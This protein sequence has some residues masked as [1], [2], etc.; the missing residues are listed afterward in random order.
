[1]LILPG[2]QLGQE[3]HRSSNSIIYRGQRE[4]DQAPVILKVLN[5]SYPT[6]LERAR[7]E[8][9]H[10]LL[11][12]VTGPRIIE[13]FTLLSHQHSLVLV[14]EDF[15]AISLKRWM[16][17][18]PL[19]LV[20]RVEVT[21]RVAAALASV[22]EQ[23]VIHKD[24]NPTNIVLNPTTGQVKLIDFGLATTLA[25]EEATLQRVE[26]M[27]GT[28]PYLA[29]EQT[30]RMN[31]VVDY[32]SDFYSLGVT[33]YEL[34]TGQLPFQSA[35]PL[36]LVHAH[37]ARDPVPPHQLS[38]DIPPV[39]SEIVLKLMA[40]SARAR[41]QSTHGLQTDLAEVLRQLQATGTV[42]SFPLGRQDLSPR[43]RLSQTLYG[44]AVELDA[45]L[46]AFERV[47]AGAT[48]LLLVTGYA[49]VGKTAL[50]NELHKPLLG[51]RGYFV[52]GKFDQ[53]PRNIPYSALLQTFRALVRQIL[54]ESDAQ[55]ARWRERLL[56]A[57]GPNGQLILDVIPEME[58]LIGPQPPAP[59]VGPTESQH[60]FQRVTQTLVAAFAAPEHP[61]VLFL[62]DLQWAD[63]ASLKLLQLFL[64]DI[65]RQHFLVLGAYRD[66]E[67]SEQHPLLLLRHDLQEAAIAVTTLA[68]APLQVEHVAQ[69]VA[70]TL[71]SDVATVQ[72]LADVVFAKTQGNPFFV[73]EFLRA[74]HK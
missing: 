26:N 8:W 9:E 30:G 50:I 61:L 70:D 16:Q 29:P 4:V 54:T 53:L 42:E 19:P 45:L 48:E 66:E 43:F 14:L 7:F 64:T 72:P 25:Q 6:P 21:L 35:D 52:S 67:V 17:S 55:V 11:Q 36:E 69:F 71:Q 23:G 12:Q 62:D 57:L 20:E 65:E 15:G 18:Q 41:Y 74:L 59:E 24:L 34:L 38:P 10:E 51:R 47:S 3:L 58:L 33:F 44:R 22:H 46:T 37:I 31:R 28:L 5:K 56:A 1:M 39:L 13:G 2:Y 32:R 60:R 68:L 49:G 40:K 63:S 73:G 27:E